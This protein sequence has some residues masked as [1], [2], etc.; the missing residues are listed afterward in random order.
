MTL[1]SHAGHGGLMRHP[2][3][4]DE[5]SVGFV[6]SQLRRSRQFSPQHCLTLDPPQG[7]GM[8]T[9]GASGCL[10]QPAMVQL[11]R[12]TGAL[13]HVEALL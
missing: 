9:P 6:G 2:K 4:Q 7:P 3:R 13:F 11:I 10:E 1:S 12:D 5:S 8:C